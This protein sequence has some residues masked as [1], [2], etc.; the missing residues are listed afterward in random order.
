MFRGGNFGSQFQKSTP[1]GGLWVRGR[2]KVL[3]D[4]FFKFF[5]ACVHH[6]DHHMHCMVQLLLIFA[7]TSAWALPW[8]A[9]PYKGSWTPLILMPF[10]ESQSF[11]NGRIIY[12]TLCIYASC[13]LRILTVNAAL[14][15]CTLFVFFVLLINAPQIALLLWSILK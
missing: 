6:N 2:G 9:A 8:D 7:W 1:S 15:A 3:R 11:T 5:K 13:S 12:S 14:K 10:T 4:N